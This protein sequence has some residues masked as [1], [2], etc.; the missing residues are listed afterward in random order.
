MMVDGK[1][2]T[3]FALVDTHKISKHT[4][5]CGKNYT[6]ST[7]ETHRLS[8]SISRDGDPTLCGRHER[9]EQDCAAAHWIKLLGNNYSIFFALCGAPSAD[10]PMLRWW[11]QTQTHTHTATVC[12]YILVYIYLRFSTNATFVLP[13]TQSEQCSRTQTNTLIDAI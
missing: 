6:C 7:C 13:R 2:S 12:M 11:S 3:T 1:K 9:Q 5:A 10:R 8:L 4:F